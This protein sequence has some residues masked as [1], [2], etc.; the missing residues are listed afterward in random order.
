MNDKLS[1]IIP[2]YKA[3]T[4]LRKCLDSI[5]N[6]TYRNIEIICVNDGSPDNSIDILKEYEARDNRII[7]LD[8]PN[9]GV[10]YAR[11]L[12]IEK[13][14][15]KWLTFSDAD[16]WWEL[17]AFERT[18]ALMGEYSPDV[19][20][21]SYYRDYADKTLERNN[22]FDGDFVEF[23]AEECENLRKRLFGLKG[24]ELK[25]IE[26][27][28]TNNSLW[29]KIYLTEVFKRHPEVRYPDNKP[30]GSGG[31]GLFNVYYFKY[32]NKAIFI[33]DHLYHYR[34]TNEH[35]IVSSYKSDFFKKRKKLFDSYSQ[36]I[37]KE[38]L[39]E[40]YSERLSNRLAVS[41]LGI[42]LQELSGSHSTKIKIKNIRQV[43]HDDDYKKAISRMDLK[44]IPFYWKVFF[45]SCK[46]R[47]ACIVYFILLTINRLKKVR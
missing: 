37:I 31:D 6:Q 5:I 18:V 35:S 23:K 29:S 41:I 47:W 24:K 10:S 7:V 21:F 11:N 26:N 28:D 12:G 15:G 8:E 1:V 19:I 45:L 36:V 14:S 13:A 44:Y 16:D 3:E 22:I 33:S 46:M 32:V 40:D 34:K 20:M 17:N 9:R 27:F 39:N 42:G 43:L 4:Y 25:H 2:V 30:I 38:G